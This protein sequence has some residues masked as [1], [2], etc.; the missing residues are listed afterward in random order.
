MVR[1]VATTDHDRWVITFDN[2]GIGHGFDRQGFGE[3]WLQAQ[4]ISA[5]HVMGRSEDW[6]QYDD[7]EEALSVVRAAVSRASRVMTYGSSMGGYA[8]IRF[9]EAVGANAVLAFSPQYTLD[10]RIAGHDG[11]WAQDS[12]RIV[13][14]P[15]LNGPVRCTVKP[16]IVY[17]SVSPDRW[18]AERFARDTTVTAV[19]L[20]HTGHPVTSFLAEVGFLAGLVHETLEGSLDAGAFRRRVREQRRRSG[21]YLGQLAENASL[22]RP[23]LA[24]SLAH[25]AAEVSNGNDLA[26]LS[27]ARLLLAASRHE[28]ALKIFES[29]ADRSGRQITYLIAYA[30]ALAEAGRLDQARRLVDEVVA[31]AGGMAHVHAWAASICWLNGDVADARRMIETAIALDPGS[32]GYRGLL[33]TY[34]FGRRHSGDQ[35]RQPTVWLALARWVARRWPQTEITRVLSR[36]Q[37]RMRST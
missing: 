36:F 17:D 29:L 23:G 18:H 30:Q 20:P 10:P 13:W 14:L 15:A 1:Q 3:A 24:L 19:T 26:Q 28:E 5:I 32:R 6:Y 11:R 16:V 9:A 25:R 7:L 37:R 35:S 34:R 21:V 33:A 2:Y 12:R 31:A 4:G 8:A 22:R 27:L